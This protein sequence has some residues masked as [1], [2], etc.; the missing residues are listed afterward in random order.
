MKVSVI[1]A[2]SRNVGDIEQGEQ[3]N[4]LFTPEME[5]FLMQKC[6]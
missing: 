1:S 3:P 6:P 5:T 4:N 2:A